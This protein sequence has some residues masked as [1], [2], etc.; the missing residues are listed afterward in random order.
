MSSPLLR[1]FMEA[2]PDEEYPDKDQIQFWADDEI[3]ALREQVKVLLE[4]LE[5]ARAAA[6]HIHAA[7]IDPNRPRQSIGAI[8]HHLVTTLDVLPQTKPK[9]GK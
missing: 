6:N 9:D 1:K 4:A 8:A 2:N 7:C 3:D 5:E